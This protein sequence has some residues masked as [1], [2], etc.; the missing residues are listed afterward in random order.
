MG[1]SSLERQRDYSKYANHH[2][3]EEKGSTQERHVLTEI[4]GVA[5]IYMRADSDLDSAISFLKE[6]FILSPVPLSLVR[7]KNQL[8]YRLRGGV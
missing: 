6:I 2:S 8:N 3:K 5:V 4:D 1:K 7:T